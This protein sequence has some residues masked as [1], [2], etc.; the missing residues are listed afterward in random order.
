[1]IV[2]SVD[3]SLFVINLGPNYLSKILFD[4]V[5]LF[6]MPIVKLLNRG[7]S[8]IVKVSFGVKTEKSNK[9]TA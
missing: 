4:I 6:D 1:M 2:I 5:K 8:I 3:I 7:L 9:F